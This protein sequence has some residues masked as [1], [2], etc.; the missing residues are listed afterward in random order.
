MFSTAKHFENRFVLFIK[1]SGFGGCLSVVWHKR[2][3][4]PF[5][6]VDMKICRKYQQSHEMIYFCVAWQLFENVIRHLYFL[7]NAKDSL[8]VFVN[9][10]DW[11]NNFL[12]K[13][14]NFKFRA[15]FHFS[16]EKTT[17]N[18]NEINRDKQKISVYN[19]CPLKELPPQ[20]MK[21][22]CVYV[23]PTH[24]DKRQLPLRQLPSRILFAAVG[25]HEK[26]KS[27]THV[28]VDMFRNRCEADDSDAR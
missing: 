19:K 27:Q 26:K 7:Q 24:I 18:I 5:A 13:Q 21:L 17:V 4:Q 9:C 8:E 16:L 22:L 6:N 11:L 3:R 25:F 10:Q 12:S 15:L 20:T 23:P 1:T 2:I 28:I 14:E